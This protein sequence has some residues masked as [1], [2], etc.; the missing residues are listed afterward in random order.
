M[1]SKHFL[2]RRTLLTASALMLT[3]LAGTTMAQTAEKAADK[4][5]D[6]PVRII[7]AGP[8]GANADV[9]ALALGDQM[10]RK[11][12]QPFIVD[13]KPGAAV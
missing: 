4:W 13:P 8:V 2:Q 7:V 5:P 1:K 6:K 9:V 11:F 12:K 10:S 3:S